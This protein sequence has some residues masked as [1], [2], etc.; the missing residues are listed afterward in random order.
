[1]LSG[2]EPGVF[3]SEDESELSLF[4]GAK[5]D[6][7][8]SKEMLDVMETDR[9]KLENAGETPETNELLAFYVKQLGDQRF[10]RKPKPFDNDPENMRKNVE[11]AIRYAIDKFIECEDTKHVGYHLKDTIITGID[12]VYVGD[13]RWKLF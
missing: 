9:K 13:W 12:C 2:N 10:H 5:W 6:E 1:M 8:C 4:Q 3:N 7:E 11:A